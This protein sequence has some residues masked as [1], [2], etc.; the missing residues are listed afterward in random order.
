MAAKK[1][2]GQKISSNDN[3]ASASHDRGSLILNKVEVLLAAGRAKE[4]FDLLNAQESGDPM[5]KNARG[6]CLLHMGQPET[7]VRAFRQLCLAPGGILMRT[8]VPVVFKTNFA[9]G[10]LMSNRVGGCLEVIQ[11]IH[12]ETH[13]SVQRLRAAI[14]RWEAGLTFRQRLFWK[15]GVEPKQP[16]AAN[17]QLRGELVEP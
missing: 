8:D 13:P 10:L 6:V 17:E 11:E 1:K 5:L 9:T 7:A 4:A 15:L 3:S 12:N 16:V 14:A 2:Q